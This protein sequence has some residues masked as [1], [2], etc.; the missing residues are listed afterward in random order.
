MF[1]K[2]SL[3]EFMNRGIFY[4]HQG[5]TDLVAC[6]PLISYYS[7][8]Y[9]ELFVLSRD[10]ARSFMDY[11]TRQHTN[12]INIYKQKEL[13]DRY[14]FSLEPGLDILFHG[15]HDVLRS[16]EFRN[17]FNMNHSN[18]FG[19]KFYECY[20]IDFEKKVEEFS[21]LRDE[22]IED[23]VLKNF[24]DKYGNDFIL[25][26]ENSNT[27]GGNT[28][29]TLSD[30]SNGSKRWVHLQSITNNF[31][32]HLKV[33][34]LA[35]E[36]HLVDSVWATVCYLLDTKYGLFKDKKIYLYPF[37]NR[38]GGLLSHIGS[39]QLEPIHPS[40]WIIKKI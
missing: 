3:K 29:I 16:D 14:E 38:D 25:Y 9:K 7:K 11:Y 32:D 1:S 23:A 4:T 6:L 28:G 17:R 30:F 13:L 19:R 18:H 22:S 40:N 34:E 5:W 37:K 12:V 8:I 15:G 26:H 36:L 27:I 10:D 24:T 21:I 31:F 35:E 33:L 2:N 39:T 20:D